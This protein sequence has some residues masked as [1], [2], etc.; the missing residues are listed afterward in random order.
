[1]VKGCIADLPINFAYL[2]SFFGKYKKINKK[3]NLLIFLGQTLVF[4][5]HLSFSAE[6]ERHLSALPQPST[7][8]G[9]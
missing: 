2:F 1:V 8:M 9:C 3:N 4:G 5:L 7:I 6:G